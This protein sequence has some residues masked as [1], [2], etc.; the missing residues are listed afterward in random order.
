MSEKE[1]K[2][3]NNEYVKCLN[4]HY[5]QFFDG[6]DIELNKDTCS[7][8]LEKIKKFDFYKE[9]Q[10]EYEEYKKSQKS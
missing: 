9:L 2:D 7:D 3:L 5:D 1:F 8:I 10:S 6:K 4:Y